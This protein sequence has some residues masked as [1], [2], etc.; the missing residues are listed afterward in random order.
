MPRGD[1]KGPLGEGPMTGRGAG[2]CGGGK[3]PGYANRA[4]GRRRGAGL[5]DSG[6]EGRGKRGF[7]NW[8]HATGIPGWMRAGSSVPGSKKEE[9]ALL[10]KQSDY[11]AGA[12]AEVNARITELEKAGSL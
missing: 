3:T 11:L 5:N 7:R 12:L 10:K 8:F 2:F 1:K 9:I 4:G 6:C